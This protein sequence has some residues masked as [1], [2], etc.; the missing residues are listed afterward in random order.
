MTPASVPSTPGSALGVPSPSGRG[1]SAAAGSGHATSSACSNEAEATPLLERAID[2]AVLDVNLG[3]GET[4]EPIAVELRK[5]R[6]PF[7]LHTGDLDRVLE[8][9]K[10]SLTRPFFRIHLQ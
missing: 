7:L 8:G 9:K 10:V 4:C 1:R 6:I 2:G 5:R 3:H